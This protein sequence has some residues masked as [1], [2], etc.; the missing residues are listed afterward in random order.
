M[1]FTIIA[2]LFM[3]LFLQQSDSATIE[4]V[5]GAA[6]TDAPVAGA[7]VLAFSSASGSRA[8]AETDAEGRFRLV[9][10]PGRYQVTASKQGFSAPNYR[11]T[12]APPATTVTTYAGQRTPLALQLIPTGT[13]TGRVFDPQG[14]VV[15]G[16][17]VTL[18]R[19]AWSVEGQRILQP[20]GLGTRGAAATND[21]GEYRL[22]WI[23][24]GDYYL[25]VRDNG[26]AITSAGQ[27]Q[28][29]VTTYYPGVASVRDANTI[30]VSPG[31]E[32]GGINLT[33]SPMRSA[34]V[35][36]RLVSPVDAADSVTIVNM[37]PVDESVFVDRVTVTFNDASKTFVAQN[38][39]PGQY[40][41][42]ATL[43]IPNKFNLSGETIVNVGDEPVNNVVLSVTPS[44]RI[45]GR[46]QVQ[47]ASPD[48]RRAID[49]AELHVNLRPD[50]S[51]AFLSDSA[52]VG[53]DGTF[54]VNDVGMVRYRLGLYGLPADA[55][56]ASARLGGADILENG[57]TLR[58]DPP[59]LMEITLSGLGGRIVGVVRNSQNEIVPAGKV[60][61]VP[62]STQRSRRD[63]FKVATLDQ[64]G[65]FN[66]QG[67]T[68]GRYRLFAFD[69]V[70]NGAYFDPE[71][72]RPYEDQ[73]KS[74]AVEK[75]DYIQAEITLTQRVV[76]TGA[77]AE[78]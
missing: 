73:A 6:G 26:G 2:S 34:T 3:S 35:R 60:V 49:A 38:V 51:L 57:F 1:V 74:V 28:K 68:P 11:P 19:L 15:E 63:L 77:L 17:S 44:Q 39:I 64:Y 48:V 33:M 78:R 76:K 41:I 37:S 61:L 46:L 59:G 50:P 13:I 43:R 4:G 20:V 21:L 24:T 47:D 5:V 56:I 71:F 42:V 75:N 67:V 70:P 14:R 32:L 7:N 54:V 55:Y 23:P 8:Q 27:V 65:R 16:A 18:S 10:Q 52:Q 40:R 12:E 45:S 58:G 29:Y 66:I 30:R 36:G 31:V 72:L 22:Y 25:T 53:K 62:D 69:D 9:V